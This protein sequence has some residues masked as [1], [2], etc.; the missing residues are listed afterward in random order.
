V[1]RL[2][3]LAF[4]AICV[5]VPSTAASAARPP[6]SVRKIGRPVVKHVGTTWKVSLRFTATTP[7]AAF[8]VV[9]RDDE[10]VQ[11]FRFASGTGI[12]TVGPFVFG[13]AGEYHFKLTLTND[14]KAER[15]LTWSACL[16][17]GA[18]RPPDAPLRRLGPPM[19]VKTASGWKVTVSFET[20]VAGAAEI[21]LVQKGKT[22]TRYT[23]HP[24][25]GRVD[26]GPFVI[27]AGHYELILELSYAGNRTRTL[28]W[29][30][31][32]G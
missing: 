3:L 24:K 27:P 11:T 4:V 5:G 25:A 31:A 23:F 26:V 19:V 29:D 15:T 18:L 12:V 9:K 1:S 13:A 7:A 17:C 14:S 32:A 8:L 10:R 28:S 20:R 16:D 30:I 2:A 22:L 6:F 21:R